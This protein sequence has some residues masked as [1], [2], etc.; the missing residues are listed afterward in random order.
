MWAPTFHPQL[1][2]LPKNSLDKY[3][4]PS[5]SILQSSPL[6]SDWSAD[7]YPALVAEM[8]ERLTLLTLF[9]NPT[10]LLAFSPKRLLLLI[11]IEELDNQAPAGRGPESAGLLAGPEPALLTS[12]PHLPLPPRPPRP[13]APSA[14]RAL[15]TP[16]GS[17]TVLTKA[18]ALSPWAWLCSSFRLKHSPPFPISTCW[19]FSHAFR[20]SSN[21]SSFK[22]VPKEEDANFPALNVRSVHTEPPRYTI[23]V[24]TPAQVPPLSLNSHWK[25][26]LRTD[27]FTHTSARNAVPLPP[28]P[29]FPHLSLGLP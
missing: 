1:T 20:P 27:S 4:S 23:P 25:W 17:S 13:G 29:P 10:F 26:I 15:W 5:A 7:S 14:C 16:H 11:R 19:N 21:I 18:H 24:P 8:V 2:C 12:I 22:I 9:S 6:S 3:H 28:L